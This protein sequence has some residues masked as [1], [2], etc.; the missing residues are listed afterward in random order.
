MYFIWTFFS[1][2]FMLCGSIKFLNSEQ[3]KHSGI[4]LDVM[5][6][7]TFY[8]GTCILWVVFITSTNYSQTRM[9]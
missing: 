6:Q 4:L 2:F 7:I 3:M 8:A 9:M 5:N 1:P